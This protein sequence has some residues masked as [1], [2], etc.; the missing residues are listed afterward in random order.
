[1]IIFSSHNGKFYLCFFDLNILRCVVLS[2]ARLLT[3]HEQ[4]LFTTFFG[5]NSFPYNPS[6]L[7]ICINHS[8]DSSTLL[9]QHI[10]LGKTLFVKT[11][12]FSFWNYLSVNFILTA[13]FPP[14]EIGE[15]YHLNFWD[16]L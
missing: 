1:M 16:E 12:S 9:F 11:N 4:N 13:L 15:G 5:Q 2:R 14:R 8:S 6:W 10:C 7:R 3:R